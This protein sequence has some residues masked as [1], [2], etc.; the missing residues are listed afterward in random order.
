MNPPSEAKRP[1][2]SGSR[3]QPP[4]SGSQHRW[5]PYAVLTVIG[6]LKAFGVFGKLII[7]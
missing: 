5:R 7:D 4:A 1:V 3:D 6:L 2:Q